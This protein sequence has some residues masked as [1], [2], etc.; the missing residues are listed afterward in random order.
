MLVLILCIICVIL[1]FLIYIK[2]CT[3][4]NYIDF[5]TRTS[6]CFRVSKNES[7]EVEQNHKPEQYAACNTKKNGQSEP[8]SI[9]EIKL[10]NPP[11]PSGGFGS[12][13]NTK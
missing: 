9:P 3:I 13:V 11:R 7:R 10:K 4:F 12:K 6:N 8:M 1:N 2:V 5:S